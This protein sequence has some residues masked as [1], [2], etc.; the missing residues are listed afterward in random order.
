MDLIYPLLGFYGLFEGRHP[1]WMLLPNV[2]TFLLLP[3]V[4]QKLNIKVAKPFPF[5]HGKYGAHCVAIFL[6]MAMNCFR[7][8][9]KPEEWVLRTVAGSLYLR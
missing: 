9:Q 5:S 8:W 3:M 4:D 1:V 7:I 2:F 6:Y